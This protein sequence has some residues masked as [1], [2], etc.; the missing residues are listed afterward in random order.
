VRCPSCGCYID[1]WARAPRPRDDC[2][3]AAHPIPGWRSARMAPAPA[4]NRFALCPVVDEWESRGAVRPRCGRRPARRGSRRPGS[5]RLI[6]RSAGKPVL[7][8]RPERPSPTSAR[9]R[10]RPLA[11]PA[12][13]RS[14]ATRSS[15][16]APSRSASNARRRCSLVTPVP[17]PGNDRPRPDLRRVRPLS[18]SRRDVVDPLRRQGCSGGRDVLP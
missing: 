16:L 17:E 2:R 10:S 1:T 9:A 13:Q 3:G 15:A 11:H 6:L 5:R 12:G 4:Q 8:R 7:A 18:S 14:S